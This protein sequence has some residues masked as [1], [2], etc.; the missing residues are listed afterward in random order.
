MALGRVH[1]TPDRHPAPAAGPE[2][3]IR[4]RGPRSHP[5]NQQSQRKNPRGPGNL[6]F[7]EAPPS[8]PAGSSQEHLLSSA[9][10]KVLGIQTSRHF[11]L[12]VS[13]VPAD[14]RG[15]DTASPEMGACCLRPRPPCPEPCDICAPA[16][17][18]A[19][20]SPPAK[21]LPN[22]SESQGNSSEGSLST[23]P[24]HTL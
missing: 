3:G 10:R 21:C 6:V 4:H 23:A 17:G 14:T 1:W 2:L 20:F 19:A 5:E 9:G 12:N 15:A 11:I 22:E 24:C 7:R 13:C 18:L 8:S 16:R